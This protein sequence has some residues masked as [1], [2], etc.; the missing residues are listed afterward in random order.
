M[1]LGSTGDKEVTGGDF[2]AYFRLIQPHSSSRALRSWFWSSS[3]WRLEINFSWVLGHLSVCSVACISF[4]L[5]ISIRI[6]MHLIISDLKWNPLSPSPL[7]THTTSYHSILYFPFTGNFSKELSTQGGLHFLNV[8]IPLQSGCQS[9]KPILQI[10]MGI[11]QSL[12]YQTSHQYL[13]QWLQSFN[14]SP[15]VAF[16]SPP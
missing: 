15:L 3:R 12:S 14:F 11:F 4:N 13:N 6:P 8:H 10:P 2:E 5:I 9:Q 16:M 7:Y 1:T